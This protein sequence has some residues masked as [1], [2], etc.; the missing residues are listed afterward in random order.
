MLVCQGR[1]VADGVLAP[2]VFS[3]PFAAQVLRGDERAEV[4]LGRDPEPPQD[5]RDRMRWERLRALAEVAVPRTVAIDDAVRD[6]ACPQVVIVG[7][8]LDF[9]AWRLPGLARV[10]SVDHPATQAETRRRTVALPAPD[11]LVWVPVDLSRDALGPALEA[12]GHDPALP[13][14]WVWEGVV[15]YLTRAQVAATVRELAGAS[16][17]GSTLIVNYQSPSPSARV[18]R[19]LMALL[20][21]I[22]GEATL[23][24]GE[25]WRSLWSPAR[26]AGLLSRHG[27]DVEHDDD[28]LAMAAR[29]GSPTARAQ[30]LKNG[31]V[32][33][34][35]RR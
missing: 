9:R 22:G 16:A 28:L 14:A 11:G 32:A 6:A 4:G 27:F 26:M 5:P 23:T 12:A 25:P 35:R 24:A 13:T 19:A 30:T 15:P 20:S 29:I 3:D 18:S 34:A 2:G 21:R 7:A 31:R 17:P 1:A 10:F 33:V 8:G